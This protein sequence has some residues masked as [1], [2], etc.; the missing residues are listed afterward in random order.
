MRPETVSE[1]VRRRS[2]RQSFTKPVFSE[3]VFL[4][5]PTG[6]VMPHDEKSDN[7][8]YKKLGDKLKTDV[9]TFSQAR[10]AANTLFALSDAYPTG[11]SRARAGQGELKGGDYLIDISIFRTAY[12][13]VGPPAL[14][15]SGEA[16]AAAMKHKSR[17]ATGRM[18]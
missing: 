10:G 9:I 13:D 5:D 17:L 15:F 14:A 12:E 4:P 16:A 3:G 11:A 18:L 2:R 6:F 7:A 1:A 8:L